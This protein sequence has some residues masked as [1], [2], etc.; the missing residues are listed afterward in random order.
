[1]LP[2][3]PFCIVD[4]EMSL[5]Q[6]IMHALLYKFMEVADYES[7]L[8]VLLRSLANVYFLFVFEECRVYHQLV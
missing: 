2:E 1:M 5:E 3:L 8:D 4:Q 6:E 7:K